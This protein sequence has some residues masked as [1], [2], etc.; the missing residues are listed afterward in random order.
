MNKTKEDKGIKSKKKINNKKNN[1]RRIL[2][3]IVTILLLVI[4]GISIYFFLKNDKNVDELDNN[5]EENNQEKSTSLID[6]ENMNNVELIDGKKKNNSKALLEEKNFKGLKVKDIKLEEIRGTT[7]FSAKLENNTD[8]DFKSCI[9]V[10]IFTNEDGT[11]YARLEGSI[12]DIPK[13][14]ST[15]LDASTTSD[16]TNAFDFRIE[17][18]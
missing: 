13:G 18:I 14:K 9:I 17:E 8:D 2:I 15:V 16:L 10:L 4:I 6:Y 5:Q 12:A 11:E 3:S 1:S 7:N